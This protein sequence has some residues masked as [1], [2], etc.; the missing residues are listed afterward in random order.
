MT[1][2]NAAGRTSVLRPH[3]LAWAVL[4]A[5]AFSFVATVVTADGAD[6]LAGRV[7]GDFPAFYG[8]GSIVHE[9]EVDQLYDLDRQV[10]AQREILPGDPGVLYFAYPPPVAAGYSLLA[11]MP[12]VGAYVVHTA[13]MLAALVAGLAVIRPLVPAPPVRPV[14]V[15]AVALTFVPL[16]MAVTL[17]QNSALVF[18]LVAASWRL[19]AEG[20]PS[21]AGVAL[22]LLLFKPQYAVPLIGLHLLR[23]R[24]R[25]AAASGMVAAGWWIA[26]SVMLGADWV[27]GWVDQVGEFTTLDAEVNGANAVSWLGIAEH[28]LGVGSPMAL[29]LGSV[30]GLATAALLMSIWWRVPDHRLATPMAAASAGILLTSPHAMFYDA[31]LLAITVAG[32]WA[33]GRVRLSGLV[34]AGWVLGAL[35]PLKE[36]IGF[37]PVAVAVIGGFLVGVLAWWRSQLL[38]VPPPTPV[39]TLGP[40]RDVREPPE[41]SV[42]IPAFDEAGRIEPTLHRLHEWLGARGI[43]G[44]VVVV[45]DGSG[46][47]TTDRTLTFAGILPG[48][49]VL[50][51]AE[52]RGKGYA[53]R[54]GMLA[55]TGRWR[56]FL[57]ADGS[58]DPSQLDKL[59]A[60]GTPVA[61]ASVAVEGA[62]L[63][64]PQS[65][66]RASLGR[67]GNVVIQRLVL[68]GIEDSQRGCKLFR[69][70][71]ADDVF[72]RCRIDRWGF[73]VEALALA[74]SLGHE[75]AEVGV[76]WEHRPVG[77]VRPWHYVTT[78]GDVL[79]V[80]Q[81]VGRQPPVRAASEPEPSR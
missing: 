5:I 25:T 9:G 68:P 19:S 51:L 23:G 13:L 80:R 57:D 37:T 41:L 38:G 50:R 7:G 8:A 31:G 53:V 46:D 28:L 75:P 1:E 69:G 33:T 3:V 52:N 26:G 18:L 6:S 70:D 40:G 47:D 78:I 2:S 35:H 43:D 36:L 45:D 48:L 72:A 16:F 65:A 74:R 32:V 54:I 15:V 39:D 61:I 77:H 60:A 17:G 22:G 64:R 49:Q 71:V 44:E 27:T 59:F 42:V 63:D 34:L 12:Y 10:D 67:F 55:A 76:E 29:A 62:V 20:R 4:A 24:W 11:G 66:L 58:T 30:L 79:R 21:L 81:S 73:D 56:A 14:V